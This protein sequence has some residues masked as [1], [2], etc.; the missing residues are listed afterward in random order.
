MSQ[1][2]VGECDPYAPQWLDTELPV[3]AWGP[4]KRPE[5]DDPWTVPRTQHWL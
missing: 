2:V 3:T 4:G 5:E 1:A